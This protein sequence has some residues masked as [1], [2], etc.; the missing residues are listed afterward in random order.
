MIVECGHVGSVPQRQEQEIAAARAPAS[1]TLAPRKAPYLRLRQLDVRL[2][3]SLGSAQALRVVGDQR[4][5]PR[6]RGEPWQPLRP[7]P[8]PQHWRGGS[9]S[10][11]TGD[12][13]WRW[14]RRCRALGL[15]QP[16]S[17]SSSV[18]SPPEAGAETR[19][20]LRRG[21]R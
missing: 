14:R 20:T 6:S 11:H 16:S 15:P 5:H 2:E 1:V 17:S 21:R 19:A 10:L 3:L 12:S 8:P 7:P 13:T 9:P 18:S 4:V